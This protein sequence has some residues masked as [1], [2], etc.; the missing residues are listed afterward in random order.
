MIRQEKI[1]FTSKPSFK[2]FQILLHFQFKFIFSFRA[3]HQNEVGLLLT[4]N[5][6]KHRANAFNYESAQQF[7]CLLKEKLLKQ[8]IM[9]RPECIWNAD[10]TNFMGTFGQKRCL[11][12]KGKIFLCFMNCYKQKSNV[13]SF[14]GE[15]NVHKL[16][17][18]NERLSYTVMCCGNANGD[19]M[20]DFIL[21][22][23]K[24]LYENYTKNGPAGAHY[25]TS[26]NGW[27]ESEHF[28][29]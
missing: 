20:D 4:Q 26:K 23:G 5:L 22:K 8:S 21:F 17:S 28:A 25:N 7:Y 29:E 1:G 24:H 2:N 19:Y 3:R 27:M 11:A 16:T 13:S 14:I 9:N 6:P 10:E 15:R 18:D 12:K